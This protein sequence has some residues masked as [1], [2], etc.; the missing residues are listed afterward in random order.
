[1]PGSNIKIFDETKANL[2][3]DSDYNLNE[4]RTGGVQTGIASS[5]LQNKFAYQVSLVCYSIAQLMVSNGYNANDTDTISTF[6]NNLSSSVMQKVNDKASVQ[7]AQNAS[8]VNKW[9]S[10]ALVKAYIDFIK[11]TN[12]EAIAGTLDTK[13]ITPASLQAKLNAIS[14]SFAP[15]YTYSDQDIT[16]GTTP[17]ETGKLYLVYE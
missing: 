10:P 1:M 14:S 4:Q 15:S 13:L 8:N 16:A 6:V 2:L 3:P 5:Q 9:V 11:A 12:Q 7:E 17:L